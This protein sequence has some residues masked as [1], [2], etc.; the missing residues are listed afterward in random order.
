MIDNKKPSFLQIVDGK[1]G[2]S[3]KISF[4][5]FDIAPPDGIEY[6]SKEYSFNSEEEIN[7]F[8]GLAKNETLDSLFMK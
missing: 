1:P 4:S 2:L 5:D 3:S 6:L 8:I 7:N